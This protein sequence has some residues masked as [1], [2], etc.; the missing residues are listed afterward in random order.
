MSDVDSLRE[1]LQ[2]KIAE[3]DH[4]RKEETERNTKEREERKF[5]EEAERA[6]RVRVEKEK[7]AEH[8]RRKEQER[9]EREQ[10]IQ[11]ETQERVEFERKQNETEELNRKLREQLEYI[12][13]EIAKAEF[14]EEQHRKTLEA[15]QVSHPPV[16]ESSEI[17]V[18][19]PVSPV[20]TVRPGEAVEGTEGETPNNPLMS[21]HLK[22][23]LRQATR[24]Y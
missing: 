2:K 7:Q 24:Y 4:Q 22:H 5:L 23:I 20:N 17:N 16:V 6:E 12:Q 1:E 10:R 15:Q 13:N 21:H 11:K 8:V 3:L 9:V 14:V 18:D 19:N